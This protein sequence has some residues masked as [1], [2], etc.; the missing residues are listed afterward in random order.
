MKKLLLL[1]LFSVSLL[2]SSLTQAQV[3]AYAFSQSTG[4]YTPV[5]GGTIAGASTTATTLDSEVYSALPIGFTF[6]YNG[7][8]YTTFGLNVN[9]WI[10]MGSTAP[11]STSIPLSGTT[12]NVISAASL[13]LLG[14]QFVSA[15]TTTGSNT[16]SVTTGSL[17][18]VS[19]GDAVFGTGVATGAT[20]VSIAGSVITVS[21]NSI[22]TGTGR[23]IRFANGTIRYQTIGSAPN[24]QLVV[25]WT[26]FSRYANTGAADNFNFQIILNETSNVINTVY[27]FPYVNTASSMQVGLRGATTADYNARATITAWNATTAGASNTATCAVSGTI[28]PASGQT[29]TWTP[30]ACGAPGGLVASAITNATATIGWNTSATATGGYNWELRS[31]GVCGSGTP[32]QSG[33][34]A[35][36]SVNLSGLTSSTT[37]TYCVRASCA[38][39]TTSSWSSSTFTTTCAAVATFPWNE[40]FDAMTSIGSGIVPSC[41]LNVTGTTAWASQNAATTIHNAPRSTANYMAI[42]FSNTTASNLWSPGF[43]LTAGTSYDFSFYYNTSGNTSAFVGFTGNVLVN[44]GQ[45]TTGATNIG[46]FITATQGTGSTADVAAYVKYIV[47]YIPSSTGTYYFD[48]NVSSTSAPWYLGV[49][50]FNLQISPS[51]L[52]PTLTAT[53]VI[54]DTTAKINWTAASPAPSNGYKYEIRTSGAAGSGATGLTTAGTVGAGILTANVTALTAATSYSLYVQSDC[55]AGTS[56][57]TSAGVFV[58]ACTVPNNPGAITI[59]LPLST[60]FTLNYAAAIPAPTSYILFNTIGTSATAIPTLATGTTYTNATAYTLGADS[61]NCIT[62]T[63]VSP[64]LLSGG[65][66]NTQYNYFLFSKSTTNGCFGAPYYSTG[67]TFSAITC[68]AA[69]TLPVTSL[70]TTSSATVSWTASAVGGNA[71]AITYTLGVYSDPSR[72]ILVGSVISMG[73]TTT[74]ALSGLTPGTSYYYTITASNGSCTSTTAGSFAAACLPASLTTTDG[75]RCGTGTVALSGTPSSGTVAWYAAATGGSP[76]FTG[77]NFTTPSISTTTNYYA[78]S[79][80]NGTPSSATVGNGATLTGATT[81]PTAFCNR[82]SGYTMQTIYTASELTALGISAGNLTSLGFNITTLGDAATNANFT[83]KIGNTALTVAPTTFVTGLTSVFGPTSYT[84]TATGLQT[85]N[86]TTPFNWDGISN[87]VV[88]VK[89]DGA[90]LTN[91]A[92]TFYTATASAMTVTALTTSATTGTTSTQRLNATFGYTPICASSPRNTVTATVIPAPSITTSANVAICNGDSTALTV[93]SVNPSY[94]YAWSPATGLSATIGESVIANPTTTTTYTVTANDAVSG[95]SNTSTVTVTV[96]SKPLGVTAVA[97]PT[98]LCEGSAINL[99]TGFVAPVGMSTYTASRTS[100]TS[101]TSIFPATNITT[102]RATT[103]TNTDDNMSNNQPIGFNFNYNGSA[104]ST[105]RVSTNGFLTFDSVSTATGGGLGAY[106]YANDFT[107]ASSGLIVAPN[108]D[109]L[110]TGGNLGTAADLNNSI[111]YTTTGV[112]GSRVLTVEWK[113]MQDF[114]TTSTASYNWQIK[115]YESDGRIEFVYGTMTQSASS[116]NYSLGLSAATVT[117][118][119]TAAQLLSQT[120]AN[121]G[122]FGFTNQTALNPIPASNSTI[123][124]V[125]PGP[126]TYSWTGPNAFTSTS[127]NPVIPAVTI[128]A[129]GTYTLT[130][131]NPASGCFSTATTAVTVNSKPTLGTVSA[132]AACENTPSTVTMT[133]LLPNTAGA[134]TYTNSYIPGPVF[135][136][137]GTSDAS[138]NFSFVTPNLPIAAN[139]AII[140]ITSSTATATG[141]TALF[142]GKNVTVVVKPNTSI[143]TQPVSQAICVGSPVTFSVVAANSASGYLYEWR[144]N[145]VIIPLATNAT[146][147]ITSVTDSDAASYTAVVVGECGSA[148]TSSA[149]VL[150]V[151]PNLIASVSAVVVPTEAICAGTSA[152]FTATPINGGAAPAY[153]WK[154]NGTD[155]TGQTA[156]TFTTTTLVNSDIVSVELTSNATSCLTVATA[157]SPGITMTVTPNTTV[158]TAVT[159][160]D[161]YT[162]ANSGL[163]YTTSGT[164]TG[165]TTN[166]VTQ[167]LVLTIAP[168]ATVS[169]VVSACDTYTWANSG[170]TYTTSGTYLGTT[171]NCFT[172]ELVLTIIPSATVSTSVTACDTYSWANSGLTYTTSGTYTGTTTNCVTQELVLTITPSSTVSTLITACDTYTWA[173]NGLTYTTSGI[174]IGTTTNCVTQELV[175]TI[176]PLVNPTFAAVAPLCL[177]DTSYSLPATSSNGVIGTWAPVFDNLNS[178]TYTFTPT[179]GQCATTAT[180]LITIGGTTT[181]TGAAWDNGAPTSASTAIIAASYS[182]VANITACT[183]TVTSNAVVTIP[184]G[185]T[186]TLN[187]IITV[188]SGSTFTLESGANLIQ[189]SAVANATPINVKRSTPA[190]MRQDY[191]LW[192]SPVSNQLLLPF[193]PGTLTNRFYTYDSATNIYVSVPP[194]TTPFNT[195]SGYLIRLK[196]NHPTTPTAWTGTFTGV[197]NNGPVGVTVTSNTFNAVGNPY[198]SAINADAFMAANNSAALYFWR[199]TNNTNNSSYAIYTSAGGVANSGGD[200]LNLT[201]NGNIQVG[202]GFLVRSAVGASSLNFTNAMRVSSAGT[203][204]RSAAKSRIWLDMTSTDGI[205]SQT[206]VAYMTNATSGIDNGVDGLLISDATNTT[207][208]SLVENQEYAIQGRALPFENTDVVPMAFKSATA[209][210]HTIAINHVDGLFDATSQAIYIQDNFTNVVHNLATPYTF[211]TIAGVFNSRFQIVYQPT[212]TLATTSSTLNDNNVIVYKQDENVVINTGTIE[213]ANVKI[214]DIRGRLLIEK[215]NINASNIK[216]NSGIG[217]TNQVFVVKITS[218]TNEVVTKK[219]IN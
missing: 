149:A 205:F 38:G 20:V 51:C 53:T 196:N 107:L 153:Q 148:L 64:I 94:T 200:T 210:N 146:L 167:E 76:L 86:F 19:V 66:S 123:T 60:G 197:P 162:W 29:F 61:Y 80:I 65:I 151:N 88:E 160:C 9:G 49:D 52:P 105:F 212:G 31:T 185:N 188:V 14:R 32:V 63:A 177:G 193:S 108:W 33:T 84:H 62:N 187:G 26:K 180:L 119:P 104:Y 99:T 100:G 191:V 214:F 77:N 133:G 156:P 27:N 181:W 34:S 111:N 54:T 93:S 128:A 35:T 45:S 8:D 47:T 175:L 15:S 126:F 213:M 127:Q 142:T 163:T 211:A 46:T 21:A 136:L 173:N 68:P 23:N 199:K 138:G 134:F 152:T 206:M 118:S 3:S 114:S 17:L 5:T 145:N 115:L 101:F 72:T 7:S 195:G 67:V 50:D 161:T 141:C 16:I 92:I 109:D 48:L 215:S 71:A 102:W 25:Q 116:V 203:F 42:A 182:E 12:N 198:P 97:T 218:V 171:T 129:A 70:I 130:V 2:L 22:S 13:D 201:P 168:S 202:Q 82:F 169:T 132:T 165:T 135:P 155:I 18:G 183:L 209:G 79:N 11:V 4:T 208:S 154:V 174:Y 190:L 219:I 139:G 74:Q 89:H 44:S 120:T 137:S 121:T 75:T 216:L 140:T 117:A 184:S 103:A 57:W 170:L 87:I 24:R 192:G 28:F 204:L 147:T 90:N 37:Y 98:S 172:Q 36:T 144:K 124:F 157:T 158:S 150:T 55:G 179:A 41:W 1:S 178:G 69:A 186:V 91:N 143:A 78:E 59:T 81:Q 194:A 166:C 106:G 207:L 110:Q 73:A 39:P 122:T 56:A 10:S 131:T 113:N 85:I 164:Y 217:S 159:A 112:S 40:N 6:N 43:T 95:C 58:T 30:P 189:A 96:N 83:V 176:T 125:A